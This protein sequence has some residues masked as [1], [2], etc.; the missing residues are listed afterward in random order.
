LQ[1]V[2]PSDLAY[3]GAIVSLRVDAL[4]K[5]L[6]VPTDLVD[7]ALDYRGVHDLD[8][9]SESNPC[10]SSQSSP[11][12]DWVVVTLKAESG[13]ALDANAARSLFITGFSRTG[14]R[15]ILATPITTSQ[16][17]GYPAAE[18]NIEARA[19]EGVALDYVWIRLFQS[20]Q[21]GY[22]RTSIELHISRNGFCANSAPVPEPLSACGR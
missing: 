18:T 1:D 15:N 12:P 11:G 4:P 7:P 5:G 3:T 16:Y 8:N 17:M 6:P 21:P 10:P 22:N 2:A 13:T 20:L 9:C 19:P 14:W